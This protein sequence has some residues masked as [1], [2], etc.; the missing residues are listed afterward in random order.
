[1][2]ANAGELKLTESGITEREELSEE[3]RLTQSCLLSELPGVAMGII[4]LG[5]ILASLATLI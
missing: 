5:W 4:T 3:T 1:M 2:V